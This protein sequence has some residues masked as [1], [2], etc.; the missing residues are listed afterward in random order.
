MPHC[1]FCAKYAVAPFNYVEINFEN[2]AFGHHV[3][4]HKRDDC[5]LQLAPRR[6]FTRKKQILCKLLTD[7]RASSYQLA[8]FQV[9]FIGPLYRFKIESFMVEEFAILRGDDGALRLAEFGS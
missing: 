4:Q 5:L 8:F 7:S 2:A 3:F 1:C 6:F 9:F